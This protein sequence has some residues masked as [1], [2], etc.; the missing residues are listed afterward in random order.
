MVCKCRRTCG[1]K[2]GDVSYVWKFISI[3]LHHKYQGAISCWTQSTVGSNLGI[4]IVTRF[5][6]LTPRELGPQKDLTSSNKPCAVRNFR[7]E[8]SAYGFCL[9]PVNEWSHEWSQT[10]SADLS[11][12]VRDDLKWRISSRPSDSSP[13]LS[14]IWLWHRPQQASIITAWPTNVKLSAGHP[15]HS[16][17]IRELNPVSRLRKKAC[18]IRKSLISKVV[19]Q[20]LHWLMLAKLPQDTVGGCHTLCFATS[21]RETDKPFCECGWIFFCTIQLL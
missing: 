4:P 13:L 3:V 10:P 2:C 14:I 19:G 9:L 1:H 16:V 20:H 12:L 5:P 6:A 15:R 7:A 18:I 11:G 21:Q 8:Q 17:F